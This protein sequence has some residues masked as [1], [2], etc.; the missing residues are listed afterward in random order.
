MHAS[1][2]ARGGAT[3]APRRLTRITRYVVPSA[4]SLLVHAGLLA[5]V[6]A[7]TV[8]V[9]RPVET[10]DTPLG[11]ITLDLNVGADPSRAPGTPAPQAGAAPTPSR[12]LV[13]GATAAA[14]AMSSGAAGALRSA[15][16]TG[17]A[18]FAGAERAARVEPMGAGVV[19]AFVE[20]SPTGGASASFAG[21][22]V[23]AARRIVYVVDASGAMVTALPFVID[24]LV[25][26]IERLSPGQRFGV[27]LFGGGVRVS[28]GVNADRGLRA[29]T[30]DAKRETIAWA[31][32]AFPRGPS[33][34]LEGIEAALELEPDLVFVL[35]RSIR[36][37]GPD[38]TWGVGRAATMRALEDLNPRDPRTGKR[39]AVLKTV[40]FIER[41]PTGLL[42]AIAGLHG[43]GAG[44]TRVVG[45]D[46]LRRLTGPGLDADDALPEIPGVEGRF[47]GTDRASIALREAT[48]PLARV[49]RS[50]AALRALYGLARPEDLDETIAGAEATLRA[51]GSD[52]RLLPDDPRVRAT[53]ARALT[54]LAAALADNAN[55]RAGRGSAEDALRELGE[56][57]GVVDEAGVAR[58]LTQITAFRLLGRVNDAMEATGR[59]V[60]SPVLPGVSAGL[61]GELELE[62]ALAQGSTMSVGADDAI[63]APES[64]PF[65]DEGD[66]L[67]DPSWTI[68][69]AEA[70]TRGA[71]DAGVP[72]APALRP[73]LDLVERRDLLRTRAERRGLVYPRVARAVERAMATRDETI[74]DR[75]PGEALYALALVEGQRGRSGPAVELLT[76]L[77]GRDGIDDTLRGDALIEASRLAR[78]TEGLRPAGSARL[79]ARLARDVPGH[80]SAPAAIASAIEDAHPDDAEAFLTLGLERY[81]DAPGADAWRIQLAA[82]RMDRSGLALLGEVDAQGTLA[83]AALEI[84]LAI[85]DAL[86]EQDGIDGA[87]IDL[88]RRSVRAAADLDRPDLP[89]RRADLAERLLAE[90]SAEAEALFRALLASGLPVPGGEPRLTLGHARALVTLGRDAEAATLLRALSERLESPDPPDAFWHATTVWLELVSKNT[91]EGTGPAIGAHVTRLRLIDPDLGGEPWGPRLRRLARSVGA[92]AGRP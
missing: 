45:V 12:S 71:L 70:V 35:A 54:I 38:A 42:D 91:D 56:L 39:D 40:Q 87:D 1:D 89:A 44:D 84:E 6:L 64:V 10:D 7:V 15:G 46:E 76:R 92:G 29:A 86:L 49:E 5:G 88:L 63:E 62:R 69:H 17:A 36:R 19:G 25:A 61:R 2:P 32:D 55:P 83:R 18:D 48:A 20:E 66:R 34:P 68:L 79:L 74:L 31:R 33:D 58:A 43:D 22:S 3:P 30:D 14:R 65:F 59:L 75:V 53:R 8:T 21:L 13:P 82:L 72:V 85:I 80:P 26:S 50:G 11:E 78:D 37:S 47:A 52:Q 27:V 41:D 51:I 16:S 81:A 90:D 4:A 77:A 67:S 9:T 60:S 57:E 73:L 28:P 24:E 23:R